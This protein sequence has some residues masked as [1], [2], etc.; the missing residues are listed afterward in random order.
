MEHIE[1]V[2][3]ERNDLKDKI[4]SLERFIYEENATYDRLD[5][6]EQ[7]RLAQQHSAMLHYCRILDDR[8]C[9]AYAK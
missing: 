3:K 9:A 5:K 2:K 8:L 7:V 6:L 1:R 4:D